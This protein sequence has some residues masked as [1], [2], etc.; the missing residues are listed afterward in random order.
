[1]NYSKIIGRIAYIKDKNGNEYRVRIKDYFKPLR[2]RDGEERIAIEV[3]PVIINTKDVKA[4]KLLNEIKILE[5][6]EQKSLKEYG[7]NKLP[8]NPTKD[9]I[10]NLANDIYEY[11]DQKD[12]K[13]REYNEL[14]AIRNKLYDA[15]SFGY[16]MNM[17]SLEEDFNMPKEELINVLNS[18]NT[19][20]YI[21]HKD[22]TL[23]NTGSAF[24][25]ALA[26]D[27]L[28]YFEWYCDKCHSCL[29]DQKGF[30]VDCKTWNCQKCGH[31]NYIDKEHIY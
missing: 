28:E 26:L 9:E 27:R 1:M 5:E 7:F 22:L 20:E 13:D 16:L 30:S 8:N 11:L 3:L 19:K 4:I 12:C 14:L 18:C 29:S 21:K 15:V 2:K 31:T 10:L 25:M 17:D 24:D 23:I 6:Y